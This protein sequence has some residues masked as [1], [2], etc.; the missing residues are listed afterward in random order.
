MQEIDRLLMQ[1]LVAPSD[2]VSTAENGLSITIASTPVSSSASRTNLRQFAPGR[3]DCSG[4]DLCGVRGDLHAFGIKSRHASRSPAMFAASA[5]LPQ[6]SSG[7]ASTRRP[8]GPTSTKA[9]AQ[10]ISCFASFNSGLDS[11]GL[12]IRSIP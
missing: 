12:E 1:D 11:A 5:S 3:I 6:S 4:G 9:L 10:F 8:A 2:Q 7:V